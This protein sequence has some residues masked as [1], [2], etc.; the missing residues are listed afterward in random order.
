MSITYT[1]T[2]NYLKRTKTDSV[3]TEV[4]YLC[5]SDYNGIDV[6]QTGNLTL[7]GSTS[8]EGFIPFNNL[9]EETVL[10][11]VSSNVDKTS[12]EAQNSSSIAEL[13]IREEA[14]TEIYGTP[15]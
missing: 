6:T 14:K 7:T 12:I 10:E 15:W 2:I 1:W 3:V 5:E 11:W 9:T 4:G 13:I 8:D